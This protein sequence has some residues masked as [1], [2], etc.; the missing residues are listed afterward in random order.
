MTTLFNVRPRAGE[1]AA[2]S[3]SSSSTRCSRSKTASSTSTTASTWAARSARSSRNVDAGTIEQGGVDD[4]R[5]AREEHAHQGRKRDLKTKI[6]EAGLAMRLEHELT[7]NQILEDYLNLVSFGNNAFGIEVAAERYFNK[8][9]IA[10]HVAGVGAARGS[11]AGAVRARPDRASGRRARRRRAGAARDGRDPQDH[12]ARRRTRRTRA[13]ADAGLLPGSVAAELLHR[14]AAPVSSRTPNAAVPSRSRQ[15]AWARPARREEPP[16]RRRPADLHELRPRDAVRGE[17]RDLRH[18]A[19]EPVA[20]HGGARRDR[21]HDGA[22]RAVAFG[23]GYNSSQFDPAVDGP[24]RQAGSSF[25]AHHA[26]GG[27]L[28]RL[29]ARRPG[30]RRLAAAGSSV[31]GPAA[32]PYYHLSGDCHGGDPTLTQA[33]AKSDN[34]AFVRTELSLGPGH[35]G[36]DGVKQGDRMATRMGIDTSHFEPV[37]STTLGTNGVHPLEMAQAYSVIAADGVLHPAQFVSKIVGPDGQGAVGRTSTG[38]RVL[39]PRSRATET[40]ML[41]EVLKNGTAARARASTARRPARPAPPT[42][43]R[44]R[45]SS[46]TRRSSRRRCG[47]A[48]PTPRRR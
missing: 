2:T 8:P 24:G 39:T 19:A 1:A 41:T 42:A 13:A 38:K 32:T 16:V 10:A 3:R 18:R 33:I 7:K 21:Q 37:V 27:A 40:Q 15:R 43:T 9:M 14:R 12:R 47:W 11:R 26:R 45:G 35:Y 44:T 23:R 36:R 17:P 6:R 5:A 4:H 31:P 20:V 30:E 25:K 29:L 34:C 48:T 22:V 46:A 28:E